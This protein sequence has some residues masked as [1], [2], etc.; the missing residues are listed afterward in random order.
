MGLRPGGRKL[1]FDILRDDGFADE[2]FLLCRSNS[3]PLR[4]NGRNGDLSS[5]GDKTNRRKRKNKGSKKMKKISS[6]IEED[7][8]TDKAVDSVFDNQEAFYYE[9]GSCTNGLVSDFQSCRIQTVICEEMT[10]REDNGATVRTVRQVSEPD[11]QGLHGDRNPFVELRQRN[12]NGGGGCDESVLQTDEPVKDDSSGGMNSSSRKPNGRV[13]NKLETAESLDWKQLM[14]EDPRNLSS[15]EKS[16]VKYFLEVMNS[17]N[18]LRS[19]TVMGNEKER[20]RVYDTIFHLPWRCE[21][22]INVG[23]LVCFDSFLSL[24]TI[25]PAR[26][27][28]KFWRFLKTRQFQR[29]CAAELSDFS[30]LIVMAFGVALLQRIDISLIYHMIRGQGAVKLYVVYNVLEIFDKLCQNFGADMLQTLFSSADGLANC[31]PENMRFWLRRFIW[32]Q[33]LA[34]VASNILLPSI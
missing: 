32:D 16:P 2:E 22:V 10:V 8:I 26:V 30:C 19:T 13:I 3:D 7:P 24:L 23:F 15:V 20:E 31:S 1:S 11:F 6:S 33:T 25:M 9:N 27:V 21:L 14:S 5:L 28:M 34:V 4:Q 29:P 18:S 12:V 17:G